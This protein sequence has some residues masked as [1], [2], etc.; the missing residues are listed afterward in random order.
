MSAIETRTPLDP[1]KIA[2]GIRAAWAEFVSR[3]RVTPAPHPYV[4]ASA[5]RECVLQI[6]RD[7]TEPDK[8]ATFEAD[9]L[10]NFRR[11]S[12]R[13]RDL[14]A[15]LKRIGRNAEPEFDVIGEQERFELRDKKG[16]VAIAGKVDAR[17]RFGNRRNPPLEV[18]SW[19]PQTVARIRS[20]DDL[21]ESRWTRSGSF[22]LLAYLF[23]SNEPFGFM[24]LDRP[25]I[26]LLLPVELNDANYDRLEKFLARAEE[27]LDHVQAG[28]LPD[29]HDD[30][31]ECRYCPYYGRTCDP[32]L[33]HEGAQV[34]ADP[35]FIMDLERWHDLKPAAKEFK[36]LDETIKEKLRGTLMAIAGP[37]AISGKWG[38][39]TR[40]E[41]P[42]EVA[43]KYRVV[44]MKGKFTTTITRVED[45]DVQL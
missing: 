16:R 28:T 2:S 6:V 18:K 45:R 34:L 31:A 35:M 32:P 44:D 30:P 24:L 3:D 40:M 42:E 15:D 27:A 9:T 26:P 33:T 10:A 12:D 13:E 5:Y 37:F 22:Q 7:M 4:Y 8:Q 23:G 41:L 1:Y 19:R 39:S 25:G 29:F 14:L 11:G 17:L 20:F 36:A 43:E 38:K 21:F